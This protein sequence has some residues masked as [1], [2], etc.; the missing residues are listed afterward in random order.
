MLTIAVQLDASLL[1]TVTNCTCRPKTIALL[2][3]ITWLVWPCSRCVSCLTAVAARYGVRW[4]PVFTSMKPDARFSAFC[5]SALPMTRYSKTSLF[6]KF[7]RQFTDWIRNEYQGFSIATTKT[8][9][10]SYFLSLAEKCHFL[11]SERMELA[12]SLVCCLCLEVNKKLSNSNNSAVRS[13]YG[14]FVRLSHPTGIKTTRFSISFASPIHSNLFSF[15]FLSSCIAIHASV[16]SFAYLL[17]SRWRSHACVFDVRT[18][19]M[20]ACVFCECYFRLI[21]QKL[22]FVLLFNYML[23]Y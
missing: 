23:V 10:I 21:I 7:I 17:R 8:R 18:L 16:I 1:W 13:V 2:G 3:T 6:N 4:Y 15:R 22:I 11:I 20:Q 12:T 19:W 9:K 5:R 14:P